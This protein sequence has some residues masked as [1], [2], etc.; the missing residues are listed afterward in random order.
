MDL[1]VLYVDTAFGLAGGQYSL[2]EILKCLDREG[3]EPV[4]SS[5]PGSGLGA[6]CSGRG[7]T[8]KPLPFATRQTAAGG[9]AQAGGVR[10]LFDM[11][12]GVIHM[13]S[14]IR[15]ERIDIV[16][17]NTFRAALVSG[18]ACRIVGVPMVFH[19]RVVLTHPPLGG[20]VGRASSRI[21]AV[22]ETTARPYM[23]AHGAKIRIV[24]V[25]VDMER[26]P[27]AESEPD[28]RVVGYLGRISR[29]K[30]LIHLVESAPRVISRVPD[31]RFSV[32]GHTFTRE[33]EEYLGSVKAAVAE[34]GLDD[35]FEWPGYIDDAPAFLSQSAVIVVPSDQE[36]LGRTMLEAMATGR[37]VV[38]FDSGGPGEVITSGTNGILVAPGDSD[39]LGNAVADLLADPGRAAEIGRP[40]RKLVAERFSS[41]SSTDELMRVYEEIAPRDAGRKARGGM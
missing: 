41:R 37:P 18:A 3:V 20:L 36:G 7:I 16:H 2:I 13:I 25:G 29:D 17:A 6:F 24:P 22:S 9:K 19:N 33:D 1:R 34:R 23:Q 8:W 12:Y 30:G 40:G 38:A 5:P 35:R 4:V 26:F 27:L 15:S 31:A 14:L 10:A 11:A 32:G 21:V 39:A 28:G